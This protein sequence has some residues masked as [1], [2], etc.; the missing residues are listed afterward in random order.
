MNDQYYYARDGKRNGPISFSQLQQLAVKGELGRQQKVWC[1][2]MQEWQSAGSVADLFEDLPPDLVVESVLS[3]Q[4]TSL[5]LG[6][7]TRPIVATGETAPTMLA[8]SA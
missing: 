5:D 2:G 4:S 1:K 8:E 6:K 7:T 3:S